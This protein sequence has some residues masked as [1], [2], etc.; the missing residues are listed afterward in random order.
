M[1]LLR[2]EGADD[3]I[4]L[5]GGTIPDDDIPELLSQGV[6]QVYTPGAAVQEMVTFLNQAFGAHAA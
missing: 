6:A 3:V 1:E 5:V 2:A 4:V